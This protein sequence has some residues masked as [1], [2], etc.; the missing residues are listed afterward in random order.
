M[1][2]LYSL[3]WGQCEPALQDKLKTQSSFELERDT[4]D[5]IKLIKMIRE[6]TFS[7]ESQRYQPLQIHEINKK[8]CNMKQT[9]F[10]DTSSYLEKF[11]HLVK[12]IEECGGVLGYGS[13]AI[14]AELPYG[15]TLDSA[16]EEMVEDAMSLAKDK[17]LAAAFL[18]GSDINRYGTLQERL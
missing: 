4:C 8:F 3:V 14:S 18:Y 7:F 6:I 1:E 10:M 17:Y 11:Q 15:E 2:T 13:Q 5:S 16:T 9:R 12:M